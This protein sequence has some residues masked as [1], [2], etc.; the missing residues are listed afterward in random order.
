[1][2][3]VFPC[4]V[5]EFPGKYL[6]APLSL[7]RMSRA[8]EQAIV[9]AVAARIPMWKAGLLTAAG[10]A[11]L[12]Q[13]T[14]SAIPV[15]PAICYRLSPR[16]SKKLISA[17]GRSSRR[18]HR[19]RRLASAGC[20]PLVCSPKDV[21]GLGLP[22]LRVMGYALRLRWATPRQTRRRLGVAAV[23]AVSRMFAASVTIVVD[24]SM[25]FWN[26]SWLLDGPLCRTAPNLFRVVAAWRWGR[27]VCD[28]LTGA[29][30][31]RDITGAPTTVVLVE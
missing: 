10:R 1:M 7:T 14:I 5:Q 6:G 20:R 21:G 25:R 3:V 27:T 16:P 30:W 8:Q 26:D 22:D 18:V 23:Q 19:R 11:T 4:Q 12:T 17:G 29:Q 31:A 15:H 24:A 13:T 9:D 2:Q 28:A